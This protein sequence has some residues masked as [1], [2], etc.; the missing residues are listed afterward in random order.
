[1]SENAAPARSCISNGVACGF[2]VFF[3]PVGGLF[4]QTITQ[5]QL[6]T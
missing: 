1:M 4:S 5:Q 2:S 6:K 3:G